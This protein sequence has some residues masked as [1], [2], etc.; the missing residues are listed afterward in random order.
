MESLDQQRDL[1]EGKSTLNGPNDEKDDPSWCLR[2]YPRGGFLDDLKGHLEE[3]GK[4]TR[5]GACER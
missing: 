4:E 1:A 5:P 2:F 3:E